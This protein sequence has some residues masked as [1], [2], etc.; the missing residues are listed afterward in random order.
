M[1][2]RSGEFK[3]LI[4]NGMSDRSSIFLQEWGAIAPEAIYSS[5]LSSAS[6][7]RNPVSSS[8][9]SYLNHDFS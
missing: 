3:C 1:R 2:G 6:L 4:F 9:S 5:S 8:R 7:A